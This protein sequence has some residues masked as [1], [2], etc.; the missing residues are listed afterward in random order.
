MLYYLGVTEPTLRKAIIS[1]NLHFCV[2][3]FVSA[4]GT[5]DYHYDMNSHCLRVLVFYPQVFQNYT[6]VL[7]NKGR[8]EF[9]SHPSLELIPFKKISQ[10]VC[11]LQSLTA[12]ASN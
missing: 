5:K 12:R 8:F 11:N 1:I 4:V 6:T 9:D 3:K 10:L 7:H 2:L